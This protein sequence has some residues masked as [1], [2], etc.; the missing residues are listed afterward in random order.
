MLQGPR[1][2]AALGLHHLAHFLFKGHP[3]Q[4]IAYTLINGCVGIEV[5]LGKNNS[6]KKQQ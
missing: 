2:T 5:G 3:G 1:N 4:Q 6:G